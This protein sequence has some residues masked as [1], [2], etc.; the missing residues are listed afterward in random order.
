MLR[1]LRTSYCFVLVYPPT[2]D[3]HHLQEFVFY[4]GEVCLG[5]AMVAVP[6]A[7]LAEQGTNSHR[8]AVSSHVLQEYANMGL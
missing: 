1:A 8:S 3:M 2:L 6:G 5:A 4:D 7:S